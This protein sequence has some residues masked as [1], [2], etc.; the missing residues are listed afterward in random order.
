MPHSSGLLH[1]HP[2]LALCVGLVGLTTLC[3]SHSDRSY[4]FLT[5]S[6]VASDG[7][8]QYGQFPSED[9]PFHF[10][11][12]TNTSLPPPLEDP[13]PLDTWTSLFDPDP[14]HWNWGEPNGEN[15]G[16]FSALGIYLCGYL[17]LPLDY[18]NHSDTR[19]VRIAVTKYQV[20][21][22][23]LLDSANSSSHAGRKS[24][25][26]IIIEP[27][28]PGGSGTSYVWSAAEETT[29]RFS[30]GQFDVLGWDP[31][32]VNISLPS[33][34]C[35][36]NNA[37]RDRW[38][39]VTNQHRQVSDPER[40][41]QI[42][43]AMNDAKFNSCRQRLGDFGR[44]LSTAS[45]ARDLEEIR[46]ALG[47]DE[48]TGYFVSYGTGIAQTFANMFPHS[49]GRMILDG[50]EYVKDHRLLGGYA[51][52][53]L[54]NSTDIWRDGFLGECI[55]AGPEACAL[56]RYTKTN[57]SVTLPQLEARINDLLQSLKSRP[58]P[59]YTEQSG[60]SLATYSQLVEGIYTIL[61]D[62]NQWPA[63]AEVLYDL[64]QG[65][66]TLAAIRL[67]ELWNYDPS[68]SPSR[69]HPST[70]ELGLAVICSDSY[71]APPPE[72]GLEWWSRLWESMTDQS[73]IAGNSRF[74]DVFQCQHYSKY[75]SKPAEMYRGDLDHNLKNPMLLISTTY[76]PA[77]PLRNARRL[78]EEMGDNARLIVHHGYGH[79]SRWDRSQ[80]TDEI[81][82]A[83]M[84]HG[85][86]PEEM[87]VECHAD[88]K[89]YLY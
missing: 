37:D 18:R 45:V 84:L 81:G 50:V 54:D 32:G 33:V 47:E 9:D 21:G 88:K 60:P 36:P 69:H 6:L 72:D 73:W 76:D 27:G 78:A 20:S 15:E 89:P 12:C 64:E 70:V 56:A 79:T 13:T 16:L 30:D 41:L 17:D 59:A 80:C 43:D 22:L 53:S 34:S 38:A 74:F 63:A 28:G 1:A 29:K 7:D 4:P 82:R 25:R 75:W 11:P 46:K 71:D 77:T 23:S 19:I 55:N 8:S 48:V 40:Q 24:A 3:H 39:L 58:I 66:S 86:L 65:N 67:N 5:P 62:P 52:T 49:V 85:T 51:W 87:E 61:Y 31:R 68:A 26:T 10:I 42:M 83:Y 35:Y 57:A 44:F 14:A 2:A